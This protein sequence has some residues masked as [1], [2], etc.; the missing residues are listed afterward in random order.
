VDDVIEGGPWAIQA[1]VGAVGVGV[2]T[3]NDGGDV[4]Q[5]GQVLAEEALRPDEP[6]GGHADGQSC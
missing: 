5:V 1:R 6:V 4:G 3:V 2:E